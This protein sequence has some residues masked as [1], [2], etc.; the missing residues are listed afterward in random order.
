M[1]RVSWQDILA[2]ALSA[3]KAR[4]IE[5]TTAMYATLEV[6][7]KGV[8]DTLADTLSSP[9]SSPQLSVDVAAIGQLLLT[10]ALGQAVT[11]APA[12]SMTPYALTMPSGS[13]THGQALGISTNGSLTWLNPFVASAN[14][15]TVASGTLSYA[16]SN[17][18]SFG[19][20]GSTLTAS[21]PA[22]VSSGIAAVSAGTASVSSGTVAFANSNGVSFGLSGSVVTASVAPGG[23]GGIA[24]SAGTESASSGTIAFAN[25]NG[26]SFGLSGSVLT[27]SVAGGGGGLAAVEAGTST[28]TAGTLSLANSNGISFG[29]SSGSLTASYTVP[30]QS[31]Q[32]AVNLA[33][34]TA[35][36]TSG[37]VLLADSN[38][39]SFGMSGSQITGSYTVPTQS[40][41]PA[42]NLAAGT[43]TATSG[44]VLLADSNGISFGLSG[45]QVTASY[46]VP[47]QS[48]QP[49]IQ[50][51]SAGS[52]RI[53]TGEAVFADSNNVSFGVSGGTVT[54]SASYSQS[55]APAAIAASGGTISSGTVSFANSNSISFGV[56]G[57]TVTASYAPVTSGIQ[58][59]AVGLGAI[60]TGTVNLVNSNGLSF[61]LSSDSIT[62]SYTTPVVSN[63]IQAVGS[64]TSSGTNT[65]RF[66]ADDHVHAG[67]NSVSVAGNT[68]GTVTAGAG[69]L[70][71]AGGSN[72]TLSGSTSGG[73]MTLSVVGASNGGGGGA[74]AGVWANGS[75]NTNFTVSNAL[76]MLQ[77]VFI[78]CSITATRMDMIMRPSGSIGTQTQLAF[79][80]SVSVGVYNVSGSTLSVR[81]SGTVSSFASRSLSW[82]SNSHSANTGWRLF[83][84]SLP[85]FSFSPGEHVVGINIS[86]SW[87]TNAAHQMSIVG[88]SFNPGVQYYVDFGITATSSNNVAYFMGGVYGTYFSNNTWT[89]LNSYNWT[90][91]SQN[92]ANGSPNSP[93]FLRQPYFILVG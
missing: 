70:V 22:P 40:V 81:N 8:A 58:A 63:A 36:A 68:A 42:V 4:G 67:L 21:V 53:T 71:L 18:V 1:I 31:T 23:G 65:S 56:S 27:A 50:S 74:S 88:A 28:M 10:N 77:R 3:A 90:Q 16:N 11:I 93:E 46:T 66:A 43:A 19:I 24:L 72:I 55:T 49:G 80:L 61:G 75:S 41:Q 30:T 69:S 15:G 20:S 87:G 34:G 9:G 14:G 26:V 57:N 92:Q 73:G 52:T 48:V 7:A 25:T 76:A 91:I 32:P 35:T 33:A 83:S 37:T 79:S 60:S 44:T 5:V 86:G 59:V 6:A 84:M 47:T 39:L 12:S 13:G 45:S 85:S 62:A 89:L 64:I 78:P 17:G 29:L 54:A 2:G 51:I 38:G 82:A